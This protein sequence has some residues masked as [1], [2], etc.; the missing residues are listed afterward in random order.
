[1][2]EE[3][4]RQMVEAAVPPAQPSQRA[5]GKRQFPNIA[6]LI[7]DHLKQMQQDHRQL[8]ALKAQMDAER[9]RLDQLQAQTTLETR[10][11]AK[12]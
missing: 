5:V 1:V 4:Q 2:L 8:V 11:P 6:S 12:K 10:K 9:Q 3:R 7:D